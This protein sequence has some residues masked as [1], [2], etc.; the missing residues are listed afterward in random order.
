MNCIS[1]ERQNGDIKAIKTALRMLNDD[2]CLMI[3]PE[4]TRSADGMAKAPLAGIG[5]LACKTKTPV[6]PCKIFGTFEIM[7]RSSKFFDWNK[8]ANIVFGPPLLAANYM[9]DENVHEKNKYKLATQII[10]SAVEKLQ[11]PSWEIS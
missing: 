11:I 8:K 3:F 10:M 2:K 5:M 1:L 4:G 9:P 6:V 7:N